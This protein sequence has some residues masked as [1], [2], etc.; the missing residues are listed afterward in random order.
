MSFSGV[1][2]RR[3]G[4]PLRFKNDLV[5]THDAVSLL[6]AKVGLDGTHR[7]LRFGASATTRRTG[8]CEGGKERGAAPVE[9]FG[10]TCC[11]ALG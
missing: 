11:A 9:L 4:F 8:Y 6:F 10:Y 1:R 3:K 5:R 7:A 2:L